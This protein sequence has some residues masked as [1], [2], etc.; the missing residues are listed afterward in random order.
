MIVLCAYV[1]GLDH[2]TLVYIANLHFDFAR[3]VMTTLVTS[4]KSW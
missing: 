4:M 1:L 2:S 3:C